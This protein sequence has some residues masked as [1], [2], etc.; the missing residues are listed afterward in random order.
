[1]DFDPGA[2]KLISFL[3]ARR[4]PSGGVRTFFHSSD[5]S[6]RSC[7]FRCIQWSIS[8]PFFPPGPEWSGRTDTALPGPGGPSQA[9]VGDIGVEDTGVVLRALAGLDSAAVARTSRKSRPGGSPRL[10]NAC[11]RQ[12]KV[13]SRRSPQ[14]MNVDLV[15]NATQVPRACFKNGLSDL[16]RI[17]QGL[18]PR[19]LQPLSARLK[20]CPC[21]KTDF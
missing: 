12:S 21:Y 2:A 1:M 13:D 15:Q 7:R 8:S 5:K 17:P 11:S 16:A 20:S 9:S 14:C 19:V 3:H 4:P 18:N 6:S 10:H